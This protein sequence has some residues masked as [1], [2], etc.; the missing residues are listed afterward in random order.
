MMEMELPMEEAEG[1]NPGN[2][3]FEA[4]SDHAINELASARLS[5]TTMQ[6]TSWAVKIFRG[7]LKS[8][9]KICVVQALPFLAQYTT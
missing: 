6:Q 9:H 1:T 5:K 8:F 4:V 7:G 2:N 3:R